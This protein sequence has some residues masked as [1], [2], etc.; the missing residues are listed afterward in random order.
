[1]SGTLFLLAIGLLLIGLLALLLRRTESTEDDPF[2][3][4][5]RGSLLASPHFDERRKNLLNR[6][7]GR[8]DWDFVLSQ[9]SKEVQRLFL[10]ERKEIALCWLSEI[11]HA[12]SCHPRKQIGE[13]PTDAGT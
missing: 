12:L 3:P 13:T 1:M 9:V 4:A 10:M 11:R 8:E 6:I 7:F 5:C 2:S